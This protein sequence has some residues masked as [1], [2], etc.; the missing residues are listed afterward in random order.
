MEKM[1][2]KV[3]VPPPAYVDESDVESIIKPEK[4]MFEEPATKHLPTWQNNVLFRSKRRRL[5]FGGVV[6]TIVILAVI[7]GALGSLGYL[8]KGRG[9]PITSDSAREP[10]LTNGRTG[11]YCLRWV[12]KE[13][14]RDS[15]N[16]DD[17]SNKWCAQGGNDDGSTKYVRLGNPFPGNNDAQCAGWVTSVYFQTTAQLKKSYLDNTPIA[18]NCYDWAQATATATGG[19]STATSTSDTGIASALPTGSGPIP[20]YVGGGAILKAGGVLGALALIT[21]SIMAF[22]L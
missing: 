4:S 15:T 5:A 19:G 11:A 17:L 12:Y 8:V 1:N 16:L 6:S 14:P 20:Y 13:I 7:L 2:E 21:P 3:A 9:A 22:V 18:W 10:D